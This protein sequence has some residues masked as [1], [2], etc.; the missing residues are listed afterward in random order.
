VGVEVELR[1]K[2]PSDVV[3]DTEEIPETV[4]EEPMVEQVTP[5]PML[6]RSSSTIRVPDMYIL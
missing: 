6:R 3:A 4:T 1:K 2:S 5:K